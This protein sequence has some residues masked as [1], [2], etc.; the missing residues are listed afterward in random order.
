[1]IEQVFNLSFP[2]NKKTIERVVSDENLNYIHMIFNK[3]DKLPKHI[4]NSNIYM[5]VLGGNLSISLGEQE[6]N[7]Y[8]TGT[9][10]KI[11]INTKMEIKNLHD[12]ILEL[13]VIKVPVL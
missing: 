3:G 9:L 10:L 1:M 7:Q 2:S 4:S 12:E 6:I 8:N 5:T 13:I 11:P